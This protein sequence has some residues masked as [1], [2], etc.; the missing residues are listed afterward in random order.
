MAVTG[1]IAP[2]AIAMG[3]ALAAAAPTRADQ[4]NARYDI[5]LA[6]MP[7]GRAHIEADISRAR[8]RIDV[9]ARL[10]GLAGAI[11]R[12]SG[13]AT[14]SGAVGGRLPI[15]AGYALRANSN[16]GLRTLRMA[17][18]GG[19]VKAFEMNPPQDERPDRVPVLPE[20]KRGVIDP[21]SAL[22]MPVPQGAKSPLDPAGCNRTLPIFDGASRFDIVLSY[23]E[24]RNVETTGYSGPVLVCEARYVPKAGHRP[25]RDSV[26]FMMENR[27]IEA[28]LAPVGSTHVLAPYRVSVRT[29]IGVTVLQA[30]DFSV[31]GAAT[32][33]PARASAAGR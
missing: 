31:Q 9:Q 24:T 5:S 29:M 32:T 6:G 12:G 14:A 18:S 1:T 27:D 16:D 2:A 28:W 21:V 25:S 11:T 8:Y 10:T 22:I 15:S 19:A 4:L 26:R 3:C 17:V 30:S 7:I 13:E 23:R 20:H 33:I